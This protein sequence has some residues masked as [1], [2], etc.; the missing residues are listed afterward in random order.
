MPRIAPLLALCLAAGSLAA[1]SASRRAPNVRPGV[2]VLVAER[3]D[4]LRGK[5][6]GLITN[7]AGVDSALRPT[8][9]VLARLPGATLVRLFAPEH[10][11]RGDV[12]AGEHVGDARDPATGV[13]V[14]SLYG[15]SRRPAPETLA[16]LDVVV[17]DLQDV[18]S[19]TYTFVST[20]GET[21]LACA[22]AKKPLIVLDRPN[23]LGLLRVEGPVREE[24]FF[25]FICWGPVP[26]VHGMTAGELARLYAGEMKIACDLTVVPAAGLRRAAIWDDTG[27]VWT[28]TSPHIP[29][30]RQAYLYVAT[31][32]IGGVA[33]NVSDGVGT[34]LPFEL[35][36]AEW[37]DAERFAAALAAENLPGVRFRPLAVQPF[38]GKFAKKVLRGVQLVLDDPRA[39]RPLRTALALMT[40]LERT[41]PGRAEYEEERILGIHWGRADVV[42]LVRA[43]R[44]AAEIEALFAPDVAA[45]LARRTP[46]LLYE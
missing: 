39:F 28:M 16:D 26:V 22:A 41:H 8:A 36:A 3:P 44:T 24:R 1:Q 13:P 34:T 38:Y 31:G 46:Y 19:R 2:D 20:L 15:K 14:V 29:R 40:A 4:L 25:N 37:I 12:P 21:M 42:D 11:I 30:E 10:G 32:M 45:F 33:K 18:G 35:L 23:P 27:L 6:F 7:P 5:R 43:G 17:F 9:D